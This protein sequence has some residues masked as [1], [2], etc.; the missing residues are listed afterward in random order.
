MKEKF[1]WKYWAAFVVA[2][3]YLAVW[4]LLL[5]EFGLGGKPPFSLAGGN[6]DHA[7][8]LFN[9]L[10]AIGAA[11][12]GVLLGTKVEQ[13]KTETAKKDTEAAKGNLEKLSSTA[14]RVLPQPDDPTAQ[15]Q[16]RE[17]M[18][19]AEK[20]LH[21]AIVQADTWLQRHSA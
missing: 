16:V 2:V 15:F 18:T 17:T 4:G 5:W 12:V 19:P 9:S 8:A 1:D 13:V 3:V 10:S 6:W 7:I 11:A 20:R 21:E 14:K